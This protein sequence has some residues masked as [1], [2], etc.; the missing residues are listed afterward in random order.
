M[1]DREMHDFL[2]NIRKFIAS[3]NPI[4]DKIV[5]EPIPKKQI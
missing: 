4:I 5:E 3:P 1:R 2:P